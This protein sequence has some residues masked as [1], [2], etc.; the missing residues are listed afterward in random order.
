M[1]N[2]YHP[3]EETPFLVFFTL[4][5][6]TFSLLYGIFLLTLHIVQF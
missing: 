2:A 3:P 6:A 5:S 4:K 1:Q